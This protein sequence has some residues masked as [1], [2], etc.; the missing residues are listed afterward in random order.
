VK[1]E[2][3]L[4]SVLISRPRIDQVFS[5]FISNAVKYSPANGTITLSAKRDPAQG[6]RFSVKDEGS[7]IAA[8]VHRRIFDKFYR[9]SE[10]S[11]EEGAGLGLSIA[12]E[13]VLAHSGTIG[14]ESEPGHGSEFFF[15]L[16]VAT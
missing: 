4:P 5:N 10:T 9:V 3:N 8:N 7:G 16:P 14:V 12:R 13:I 15:T 6:V 11:G 1:T 2:P